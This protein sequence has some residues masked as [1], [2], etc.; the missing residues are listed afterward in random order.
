MTDIGLCVSRECKPKARREA[1]SD[2]LQLIGSSELFDGAW[3]LDRYRRMKFVFATGEHDMCW[4]ANEQFAAIMRAKGIPHELAVW[5][6]HT[7]HDWPWW[8]KMAKVYFG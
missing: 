7:G 2:E 1:R 3:Y 8:N 6:N 5:G 4:D